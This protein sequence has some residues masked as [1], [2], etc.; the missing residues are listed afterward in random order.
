MIGYPRHSVYLLKDD[1]Q[2]ETSA[3]S[4]GGAEVLFSLANL[5][6]LGTLKLFIA[7]SRRWSAVRSPG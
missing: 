2:C 5:I 1:A 4:K 3:P 6:V 7:R